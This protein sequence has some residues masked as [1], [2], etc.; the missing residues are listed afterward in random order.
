MIC[1]RIRHRNDELIGK[2]LEPC[3]FTRSELARV[4]SLATRNKDFATVLMI[5][6]RKGTRGVVGAHCAIAKSIAS[7]LML[8]LIS[9]QIVP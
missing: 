7:R 5:S 4:D 2:A 8:S 3:A 9:T 1:L 6:R